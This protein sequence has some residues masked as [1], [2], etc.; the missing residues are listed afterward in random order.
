VSLMPATSC[1]RQRRM[2]VEKF[3]VIQLEHGQIKSPRRCLHERIFI[4]GLIRLVICNLAANPR[5]WRCQDSAF[6]HHA[7]A[8]D[9]AVLKLD[10]EKF[11]DTH[12]PLARPKTV[13]GH[14]GHVLTYGFPEGGNSLSITKGIVSRVEFTRIT[15]QFSVCASRLTPPINPAKR[16]RRRWV[17]R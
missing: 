1:P 15:F 2:R 6:N 7:A 17:T 4:A 11:F 3:F 10:D 16:V 5:T 12:P 9:L 14:Q 8:V 13:A